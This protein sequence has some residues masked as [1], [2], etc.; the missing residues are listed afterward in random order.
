MAIRYGCFFSYAQG[1]YELINRFKAALA[2]ALRVAE[3]TAVSDCHV[4]P[5]F[6]KC[7]VTSRTTVASPPPPTLRAHKP[8]H[9][10]PRVA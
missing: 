10:L 8:P 1:R 3:E 9:R 2:D 4:M 7:Q 5:S 6:A